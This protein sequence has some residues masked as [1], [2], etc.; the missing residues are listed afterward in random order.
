M[1]VIGTKWVF[2]N[3][4]DDSGIITRNKARLVAKGYNQV[5]GIDYDETFTLVARLEAVRVLLAFACM[6]GFKLF[7]MDVKSAFLNGIVNEEIYV[8]Q[9]LGFEDHKH[10][11]YVYKLKKAL[12]GLKQALHQWNERLSLFLLSHEYERGKVDK[13]LFIK[14]V[15]TDIIL[16]QIYV[17]DI[18]F[19][20]SN[21]K[22]CE[23]FVK[24]MQG[25]F[26]MSMMGELS[27]FL[28]LQV[29]QSKEGT[30]TCQSKYCKNILKKF[31]MEA[32]T[33]ATTPMSTNCYLE[34]DEA[35]PEVNQTMYRGL[36][37]SL[38]YL[39]ASRPDIMFV[40]CLCAR[41]QSC[42]KESHLKA[43]KRILK[44]L[45]G[46]ISMGLWYPYLISYTFGRLF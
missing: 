35:K 22:L 39:T 37:G 18:V 27:F 15:G 17:D 34:A 41:F 46:T 45:K 23:D 8:S 26:E 2:K 43:T 1:N 20:S 12:Y 42:P 9:P 28:G 33:A 4:Y 3:K 44:Y 38:L 19:G 36:I 7:Q 13:T 31:E 29:K 10:P 11:E 6:S 32:C 16:V 5:E 14:K 21:V 40:V 24:A 25:E 30:F